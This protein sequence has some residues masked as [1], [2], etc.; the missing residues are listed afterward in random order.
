MIGPDR[1]VRLATCSA[2]C[3]GRETTIVSRP[4]LPNI[5]AI[6]GTTRVVAGAGVISPGGVNDSRCSD[7]SAP[8]MPARDTSYAHGRERTTH[9]SLLKLMI[10]A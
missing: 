10:T 4:G 2:N 8:I 9:H 6:V 3:C 1:I 5:T 7:G